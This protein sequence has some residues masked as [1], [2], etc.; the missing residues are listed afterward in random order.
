MQPLN[1]GVLGTGNIARQFV[2]DVKD[3]PGHRIVAVGSRRKQSAD[4]F[5]RTFE[6]PRAHGSYDALLGDESVEAIYLSLPNAMHHEWTLAALDAGK[7]VLCEKPIAATAEQ[8]Q[9][10]FDR[11]E[12]TGR[13]LVE[14]FMYL[15]HPQTLALVDALAR[16][17]VGRLRLVR[18]SFSYCTRR[19][20]GNIRFDRS[21]AGGALMD[22]GC[23][24]V[25]LA[26]LAT[27]VAR[28][29]EAESSAPGD[30]PT[31]TS[32]SSL[33]GSLPAPLQ[34][35]DPVEACGS[36]RFHEAGV[37]DL[38]VGTLR[39]EDG[40]LS[41]LTAGMAA[42]TDNAALICGDEGYL[43]VPVPWKPP[44][45]DAH[46]TLHRMSPPK[47]DRPQARSHASTG[48][49]TPPPEGRIDVDADGPLFRYEADDFA[50][51]VRGETPP[52]LDRSFSV[53]NMKTLDR[54]RETI[55]LH[56]D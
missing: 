17:A 35:T 33:W 12:R 26:R 56:W 14:A 10:M 32:A 3:G 55:G 22:V 54:L 28:A 13:L 46:L 48:A 49:G 11:A 42:Q 30:G 6:I 39:F 50:R 2:G 23:Y 31:A 27:S 41:N 24:T 44:E 19:I 4:E 25:S 5:A 40:V 20:E 53:G 43:S 16:G 7:H 45:G 36:A 15:S 37:D 21:L 47:M 51:A 52:R 34:W 9:A 18:T 38:F 8:A 1:W 29:C